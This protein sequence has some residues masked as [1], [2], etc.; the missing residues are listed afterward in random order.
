MLTSSLWSG[1]FVFD[2][3]DVSLP[4]GNQWGDEFTTNAQAFVSTDVNQIIFK[5]TAMSAGQ[6][7]RKATPRRDAVRCR[8]LDADSGDPI[9]SGSH[10]IIL[11][12]TP[13]L[14]TSSLL[15][16]DSPSS[17]SPTP[18]LALAI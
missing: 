13:L 3:I 5:P 4:H 12:A 17:T 16:S 15:P 6:Y 1:V 18:R 2:R 9:S 14:T 11:H 7:Y 10:P 8:A